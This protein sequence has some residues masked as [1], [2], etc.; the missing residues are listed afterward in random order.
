M[1]FALASLGSEKAAATLERYLFDSDPWIRVDTSRALSCLPGAESNEQLIKAILDKHSHSDYSCMLVSKSINPS[2]LLD[3]D[4]DLSKAAGCRLISGII[5]ASRQTFPTESV[6]ETGASQC[7]ETVFR[8]AKER[9]CPIAAH[10]CFDL[11]HWLEDNHSYTLLSPPP[12][13]LVA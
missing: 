4:D 12:K 7:L 1:A 8:L 3:S 11:S 9:S 13:R 6:T 2:T 5:E 10:T